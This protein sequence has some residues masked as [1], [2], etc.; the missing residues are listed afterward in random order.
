M[1]GT[2][3]CAVRRHVRGGST[4]KKLVS[5]V[6]AAAA[7]TLA[8]AASPGVAAVNAD[9]D[10]DKV[11][12]DLE[13][14]LAGIDAGASVAVIVQLR[15]DATAGRVADLADRVGGFE[16]ERRFTLVDAFTAEMTK[17]DVLALSRKSEVRSVE[18]DAPMRALNDSGQDSFGVTKARND[19]GVDGD[20]DGSGATY[21]KDDLV[22]AVLDT[23]IDAGHQ[24][25]DEGKVLAFAD[26][27]E[28]LP[29]NP[30]APF[31]GEG[32]GTHVAATAAGEGDALPDRRYRGVAPAAALVGVRVLDSQGFGSSSEFIAG[33]QWVVANRST[34]GIEVVNASL[35]SEGCSNG[36]DAASAAVDNAV[37]AG[38]VVVVAAGNEGSA[39]C[40]IGSPGA[41]RDAITAGAMAD[42]SENGFTLASFSSR[43]PTADGRVKPDLVA[44]GVNIASSA[45]NTSNQYAVGS[46]TSMAAPFVA[47]VAALMLD[48]GPALTPAGVKTRLTTTAV[49]WGTSGADA[50]YGHGRLDAY[51]SIRAAGA[52]IAAPPAVPTHALRLGSLLGTGA[53][54][55]LQFSVSNLSYPIA[56]TVLLPSWSPGFGPTV[57]LTLFDPSGTAVGFGGQAGRH[58]ELKHFPSRTGTYTLRVASTSGGGNFMLDASGGFA[59]GPSATA[60]PTI[61]GTAEPGAAL[62]ATDGTWSGTGSI[63][64]GYEWRR[65]NGSGDAC[66]PIA[67]ATSRTYTVGAAD[68][69]AT[70]RVIVTATDAVGVGTA[71]STPTAVV[72]QAA[73]RQGPVVRAVAST[74]RRGRSVRL[75]YRIAE[76]SRK[77]RERIRV[78]RGRRVIRTI[79]TPLSTRE[80]GRTY[81]VFW[82]AP[83]RPQLLRFCVQA[84][85]ANG[86]ASARSCAPLRIR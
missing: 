31:D 26:C 24:D 19:A 77:T 13:Q 56:S 8:L 33:L 83:R 29:C 75:L 67:G 73:D 81:Y 12:D 80:A 79:A 65:C 38:L 25:L 6:A 20:G 27:T 63:S 47:G 60:A 53:L 7:V 37:A 84:W 62:I 14:R 57:T 43:G 2:M 58:A 74:G 46:G 22:I 32:H 76:Q 5:A 21:S 16:T 64:F 78:Y 59:A 44:P 68:V 39:S 45:A 3:P 51:A 10:G 9:R 41:A 61:A 70:L 17:A 66:T 23:G 55:D 40:T 52:N 1:G 54:A 69:G 36:S 82:R 42:L 50:E 72:T 49:D 34:Y 30:A 86:N 11:F 28:P 85:D 48:A 35:G 15:V 71:I 4:V 18:L